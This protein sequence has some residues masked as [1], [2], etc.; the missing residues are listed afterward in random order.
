MIILASRLFLHGSKI[1]QHDQSMTS[2]WDSR[3]R[4]PDPSTWPRNVWMCPRSR[5][6]CQ[7]GP[8]PAAPL[9]G[10]KNNTR[11]RHVLHNRSILAG[12][13]PIESGM[14]IAS[15]RAVLPARGLLQG[16]LR[17]QSSSGSEINLSLRYPTLPATP[18]EPRLDFR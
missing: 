6:D 14:D 9:G 10:Q 13:V 18:V 1:E 3:T 11:F 5:R 16:V 7:T 2:T 17:L 8:G 15:S 12:G 4:S